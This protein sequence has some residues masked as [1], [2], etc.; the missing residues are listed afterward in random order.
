MAAQS[1]LEQ[2]H[3]SNN[4]ASSLSP[5]ADS[6]LGSLA[7][8]REASELE[9]LRVAVMQTGH[10]AMHW[11]ANT[12][13]VTWSENAASV[14]G[15]EN[16]AL[17]KH[18]KGFRALM[19][20]EDRDRYE[21]EVLETT[22]VDDG[23][24][25]EY[26]L[27]YEVIDPATGDRT[28]I[29]ERGR[30]VHNAH[31]ELQDVIAIVRRAADPS[32]TD[33]GHGGMVDGETGLATRAAILAALS[34]A[35]ANKDGVSCGLVVATMANISDIRETYGPAIVNEAIAATGARLRSVMRGA[36]MLGRCGPSQFAI[37]L[38]NCSSEQIH[39][40]GD[41][42]VAAIRND[43][44]DTNLG[45]VWV[46]L[47]AGGVIVPASVSDP[48]EA[49][50]LAEEALSQAECSSDTSFV[51]YQPSPQRLSAHNNNRK[52]AN[53]I[54]TALNEERFTIWHQPIVSAKTGEPYMYESLLRMKSVDG[55]ILSAA[56]LVPIAE[57]LGFMQMI[58]AMVCQTSLKLLAAR[59]DTKVSFN[60]S[61]STL[62]NSYAAS[63]ILSI[64]AEA[65]EAAKRVCVEVSHSALMRDGS[66]EYTAIR[67]LRELGCS[68]AVTGYL[69][70]G[71]SIGVLK[72]VDYVKI[73]G[74]ICAGISERP[75]DLQLLRAAVEFARRAGAGVV[76]E[77]IESQADASILAE[78]GVDYLQ[79]F[80]FGKASPDHF[81][82]TLSPVHAPAEDIVPVAPG[83]PVAAH[84]Q[85]V[86]AAPEGKPENDPAGPSEPVEGGQSE[87]EAEADSGLQNDGFDLLKSA[88]SKLD[89]I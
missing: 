12:D 29:D 17:P 62:R 67:R 4:S 3:S 45:P 57:K 41:R 28:A 50:S 40:A 72:Q 31:G 46:E 53:D 27:Q 58:D 61:D 75:D 52:A 15:L 35:V 82:L 37:L 26:G 71:L 16:D 86:D 36:D 89:S 88:L 23:D 20:P 74:S 49:F 87:P 70:E 80:L 59:A 68:I 6:L 11:H 14:L 25:I 48:A 21:A 79:G 34:G 60:L 44:I 78:M 64:V 76:G 22:N 43:V 13:I 32:D 65:G 30:L 24:G 56:H 8:V 83:S 38:K 1:G 85:P 7:R 9:R 2:T 19:P 10:V 47:T 54:I 55:E 69:R 63:R 42:F 73:D 84:D 18:G 51:V 81:N 66:A 77:R 5:E 39:V 33:A